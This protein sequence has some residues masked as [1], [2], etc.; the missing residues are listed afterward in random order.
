MRQGI[1]QQLRQIAE[2]EQNRLLDVAVQVVRKSTGET[3]LCAGGQWDRIE[4]RYTGR[5]PEQVRQVRIVESQVPFFRWFAPELEAM[6]AGFPRDT[7]LGLCVGDRRAGKTVGTLGAAVATSIEVPRIGWHGLITWVVGVTRPEMQELDRYLRWMLPAAWYDYSVQEHLYQLVVGSEIHTIT[8]DN[9]KTLKRGEANFIVLNEGQKMPIAVLS[10]AIMGTVDHDGLTLI[11]ANQP[12]D[13]RG[14]WILKIQKSVRSGTL[15]ATCVFP[16]SSKDNDEVDQSARGRSAGILQVLDPDA[17]RTDVLNESLLQ[18]GRALPHWDP[19]I[20]VCPRPQVGLADITADLTYA[21]VGRAYQHVLG[22]DYQGT[23]YMP[24]VAIKA[25]GTERL[26]QYLRGDL[27]RSQLDPI[28]DQAQYWIVDEMVVTN[29]TEHELCDQMWIAGYRPETSYCVGDATGAIQNA[30]HK[31]GDTSFDIIRSRRWHLVPPFDAPTDR[32]VKPVNPRVKYRVN[33]GRLLCG[34]P[35]EA[36]EKKGVRPTKPRL[37]IEPHCAL[38]RK[39]L[40]ECDLKPSKNG[41]LKPYGYFAHY[42]DAVTYALCHL[43]PRPEELAPLGDLPVD[44]LKVMQE[45][46][47]RRRNRGL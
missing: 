38:G 40:E 29:C 12:E 19:L 18:E 32:D 15:P 47:A 31:V 28:V 16:M 6:A 36:A 1:D 2:E 14:E 30:H 5:D 39:A 46:V 26:R 17:Y 13:R 25:F 4:R 20:H 10:N 37:F 8:A 21:R 33:L 27:D 24:A 44:L 35:P 7:S 43:E 45:A 22:Q 23:P 34:L 11:A 42:Y 3:L 9:P 41:E